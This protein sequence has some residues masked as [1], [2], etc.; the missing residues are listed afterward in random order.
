MMSCEIEHVK[1]PVRSLVKSK[2]AVIF[3]KWLTSKEATVT[4]RAAIFI[5]FCMLIDM[6]IS[7]DISKKKK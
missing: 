2:A 7:H 3:S 5:D 6:L 4:F 1:A